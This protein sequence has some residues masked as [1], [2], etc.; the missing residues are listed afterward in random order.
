MK[1]QLPDSVKKVIEK[2][3][4][5]G[6]CGYLVGGCVRDYLLGKEPI[7]FDM[8][9]D[10]TPTEIK[11][12]FKEDRVIDTGIAHGTVTVILEGF[13]IEITTHRIETTYSD[14]R[15]P[16]AVLFTKNIEDDLARRDFTINAMAYHPEQGFIDLFGGKKDI[17]DR[18]IRCV[19]NPRRRF[20]EDAL[21]ILRALRFA[22]VLGFELEENTRMAIFEDR[23]SLKDISAERIAT[24]IAK[25]LCG[26]NVKN[27]L[28]DAVEILGVMIPEL[29]PM[30]GFNQNNHH[31]CYDVLAHTAVALENI[32]PIPHLRWAVLF[33]DIGKPETYHLDNLGIGHF[34]G[35]SKVSEKIARFRMNALR[36]DKNTISQVCTL[37]KYHDCQ[38]ELSKKSV[39][40]WLNR[41]SEPLFLDLLALKKA[42]TLAKAPGKIERLKNLEIIQRLL[43]EI[44]AGNECFSR[45][46]LRVNGNDLIAM[47]IKDGQAIGRILE[48]LLDMVIDEALENNR[49]ILLEKAKELQNVN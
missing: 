46:D 31:H 29:L 7:D 25:L 35:H 24:E 43:A 38:V 48:L 44:I 10:A 9:T 49:E 27:V 33:H 26:E 4:L 30:E 34:Y 20:N 16:D 3:A 21:R 42:D 8:T 41:L 15:H 40:R 23:E 32:Q 17:K 13:A 22:S 6:F 36:I 39:K 18:V 12:C 14:K 45:K 28:I 1:L 11:N 2:L 37:V 5:C 19:G 47:G